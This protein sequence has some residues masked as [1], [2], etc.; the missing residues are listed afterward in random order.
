M[1]GPV[2]KA[3]R[4]AAGP[5]LVA[6]AFVVVVLVVYWPATRAGFIWDDDDYVT[7]NATLADLGGLARIWFEP[8]A[9]PQYYPLVHTTFWIE[10]HLWGLRPFG[11]HLDNIW[12][13][14]LAA[15]L[16]WRLLHRLKIS[17]AALAA[18]IF[19]LHPLQAESVA[20]VTERKNVLSGV[21]YMA[22]LLA[23]IRYAPLE[24]PR[25]GPGPPAPT[26]RG[27]YFWSLALFLLALCA[28]TVTG[29]LPA[30][31][32]ILLWWKRGRVTLRDLARVAPFFAL[33]AAFGAVT[34][35]ME[36]HKVRAVGPE[37]RIPFLERCV[38]AGHA[39]WFYLVKL[40]W[41]AH[42]SFIYPRWGTHASGTAEILYP[43][44]ALLLG[45]ALWLGRGRLGRAPFAAWLF[46]GVT[47]FPAL[48]FINTFPMRY[49]FVADHFQYLACLGPMV[50]A[51]YA[52]A[53]LARRPGRP[54]QLPGS[55]S[56]LATGGPRPA[57][58]P[59]PRPGSGRLRPALGA[60]LLL[61]LGSAT[62]AR[63]RIYRDQETLWRDTLDK[64]PGAWM[65]HHNLGRYYE[66]QGQPGRAIDEYNRALQ[67]RPDLDTTLYNLGNLMAAEGRNREAERSY[68][69]ALNVNPQF[70]E[71]CNN[72]GNLLYKEGKVEDAAGL[73][74]KAV[75][76]SPDYAQAHRNLAY[77]LADEGDLAGAITHL[78]RARQLEPGDLS[79]VNRLAWLLATAS[80]PALRDG[81]S[82]IS[83]A[84]EAC[85]GTSYSNPPYLATLAAAYAATGRFDDAVQ[86]VE[87]AMQL[88]TQSGRGEMASRLAQDLALYRKRQI[89]AGPGRTE[90]QHHE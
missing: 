18:G 37:W 40:V 67:V 8:G 79:T 82:A 26:R 60:A 42:L 34:I 10:H 63:T 31:V 71:A 12:L 35:W 22:S 58:R 64:N 15:L 7:H 80:N 52:V 88:A 61:L 5:V 55:E 32:L 56:A 6:A 69:A 41:P 38:I 45:L 57:S 76:L 20:W 51:A 25:G 4:S 59:G 36:A 28:K 73:Y 85:R 70:V 62:F 53:A 81:P 2:P 72:L 43:V 23:W 75:T 44:G 89:A 13:H 21:F 48:G 17:G 84:E 77:A 66:E 78:K 39:F 68:R 46:Y 1:A 27:F 50:P 16:L 14:A 19:A 3:G 83:L 65:A 11:Y 24:D 29:S 90:E 74:T 30:V 86:A 9:V 47:L 54:G 87:H 33:A 49:S